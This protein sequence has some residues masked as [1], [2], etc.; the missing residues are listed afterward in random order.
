MIC[1]LL[2]GP[3]NG[4]QIPSLPYAKHLDSELLQSYM[5]INGQHLVGDLSVTE[6]LVIKKKKEL[7]SSGETAQQMGETSMSVGHCRN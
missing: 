1:I 2:P 5:P 4:N 6:P 3:W 7:R